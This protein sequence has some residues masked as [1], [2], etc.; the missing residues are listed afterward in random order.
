MIFYKFNIIISVTLAFM[1]VIAATQSRLKANE[2]LYTSIPLQVSKRLFWEAKI[3]IWQC[4]LLVC[5]C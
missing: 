5:L 3:K 4:I 1:M 2:R